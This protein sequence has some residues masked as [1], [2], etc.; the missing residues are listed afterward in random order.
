MGGKEEKKD[1]T[2]QGQG[3]G[4]REDLGAEYRAGADERRDAG[5]W[6]VAPKSVGY[7]GSGWRGRKREVERERHCYEATGA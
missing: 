5:S 4:A 1:G 3:R 7:L 6:I 2:G